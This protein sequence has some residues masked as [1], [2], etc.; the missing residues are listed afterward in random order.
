MTGAYPAGHIELVPGP[1]RY[2]TERLWTERGTWIIPPFHLGAW[3]ACAA[4]DAINPR[5]V[6]GG[7]GGLVTR[8]NLHVDVLTIAGKYHY[9]LP[10]ESAVLLRSLQKELDM[11]TNPQATGFLADQD[12]SD[13]LADMASRAVAWLNEHVAPSGR[14]FVLED[15]LYLITDETGPRQASSG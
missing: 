4:P 12:M 11:G 3:T 7:G 14:H 13:R 8:D 2:P 10:G 6:E 15:A 1:G 5:N 9:E